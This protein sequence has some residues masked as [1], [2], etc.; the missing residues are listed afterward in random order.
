M[1]GSGKGGGGQK[2]TGF[3]GMGG[4]GG[5]GGDY[6]GGKMNPRTWMQNTSNKPY[7]EGFEDRKSDRP[8]APQAA[9]PAGGPSTAITPEAIAMMKSIAKYAALGAIAGPGGTAA[10]GVYGA[11]KENKLQKEL[12]EGAEHLSPTQSKRRGSDLTGTGSDGSSLLGS[13]E[14]EDNYQG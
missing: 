13:S 11:W 12:A 2:W 8:D 10:G 4:S 9:R 3:S 14:D 6:S 1:G 5:G 7:W